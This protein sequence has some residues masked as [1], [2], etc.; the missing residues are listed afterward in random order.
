[1]LG[2][3]EAL[4]KGAHGESSGGVTT[5]TMPWSLLQPK[6]TAPSPGMEAT[7]QERLALYQTAIESARQAGDGAKVRRYDR[8]LKVSGQVTG[9]CWDPT[10]AH[11]TQL[12]VP[13]KPTFIPSLRHLKTCWPLSGRV[14]PSMKGTSHHLWQWGKAQQPH[15]A[16]LRHLPSQPLQTHQ[17]QSPGSRSKAL[18]PLLQ[19]HP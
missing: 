2:V 14:T 7:L 16:T 5:Q 12:Q 3:W 10:T 4:D 19:P 6:A 9:G 13:L 8:G 18:L 11:C 15:P 1:M 17:S